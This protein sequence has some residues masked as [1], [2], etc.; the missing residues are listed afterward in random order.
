LLAQACLF[1]AFAEF[2][3]STYGER[4]RRIRFAEVLPGAFAAANFP[5]AITKQ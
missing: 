2:T 4:R 5:L 3:V 1:A